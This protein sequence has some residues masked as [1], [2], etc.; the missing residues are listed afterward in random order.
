CAVVEQSEHRRCSIATCLEAHAVRWRAQP[1]V[2]F[3]AVR[4]E[5]AGKKL[6]AHVELEAVGVETADVHVL[7][8]STREPL[9]D[10]SGV[11]RS[12]DA[13]PD[14]VRADDEP[15]ADVMSGAA[16]I[17]YHHAVHATGCIY[18]RAGDG[19][20]RVHRGARLTCCV[21]QDHVEYM[22][23][24]SKEMVDAGAVPDP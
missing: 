17:A 6:F 16:S 13:R 8:R 4:R 2:G 9:V 1:H 7:D 10:D 24:R 3:T 12:R 21:E 22:T 19:H 15:S 23:T 5:H 20:A 11:D 18:G 14:T